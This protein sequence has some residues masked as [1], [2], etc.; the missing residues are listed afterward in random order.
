[1]SDHLIGAVEGAERASGL[2]VG[3]ATVTVM[4][5]DTAET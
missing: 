2:N 3:Q 1:V 4:M 5:N